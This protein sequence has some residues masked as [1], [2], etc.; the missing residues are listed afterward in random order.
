MKMQL[1]GVIIKLLLGERN[2]KRG[3][4]NITSGF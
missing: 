2:E 4:Y 1:D 3:M